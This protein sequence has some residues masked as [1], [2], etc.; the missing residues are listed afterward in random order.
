MYDGEYRDDKR[1]GKGTYNNKNGDVYKGEW[2]A[3][4]RQGEGI[5]TYANK[6]I[7]DGQWKNGHKD[8]QGMMKFHNGDVY[9]GEFSKNKMHGKGTHTYAT[10]DV[11]EGKF[12]KGKMHG[13]GTYTYAAGDLSKSIGEWKDGKKCGE[14]ENIV[15]VEV[16]ERVIYENDELKVDSNVKR[17]APFNEDTDAEDDEAPPAKRS[18]VCVSPPQPQ[19]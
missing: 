8:G 10:G 6:D 5:M 17:E 4:K 15:R 9:E 11:Y 12:S 2:L 1:H 14:F 18:N 16:S 7:Y 19:V 3:G 13:E